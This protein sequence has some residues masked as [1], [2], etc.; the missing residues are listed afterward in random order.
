ME[1]IDISWPITPQMTAY[2][3]NKVVRIDQVKNFDEH[4]VRESVMQL[5]AHSG[6]HVDAPA[7]FIRDGVT[8]E[9]MSLIATSGP[10]RVLDM[11]HV[12]QRITEQDLACSS[13][14]AGIIILFK[15]RNSARDNH[16]PFDPN[17]IYLTAS[18][19]QYLVDKNVTAVG[20]DYLGIERN[21]PL[22]E[23]HTLLL[24]N[25][26]ALIEGL[27]LAH[28]QPGDYFLL[29]MP[30]SLVGTEAAPA[31]AVLIKDHVS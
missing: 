24:A 9:K 17:F 8:I 6:T 2:K 28:V 15:T 12:E 30:I 31:R 27:R 5:G 16:A 13:I 26:I 11:M 19:A 14:D 7:H 4:H 21:Q 22:H 25:G 29:C 23:T 10:C 1:M 3:D 20:I 18:G